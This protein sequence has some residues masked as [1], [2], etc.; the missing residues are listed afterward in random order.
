MKLSQW[1]KKTN[2]SNVELAKIINIDQSFLSHINNGR[3]R[4]SP[5]LALKIEKATGGAVTVM[6]LLYPIKPHP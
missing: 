1:Q 3:R 6:E 2:I 5:K 4:P